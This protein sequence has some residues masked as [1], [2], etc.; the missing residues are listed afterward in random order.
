MCTVYHMCYPK[1]T[2]IN[3]IQTLVDQGKITGINYCTGPLMNTEDIDQTLCYIS[4][5]YSGKIGG[6]NLPIYKHENNNIYDYF[7]FDEPCEFNSSNKGITNNDYENLK[8]YIDR[9][10]ETLEGG[11]SLNSSMPYYKNRDK[12][13]TSTSE[14]DTA[15]SNLVIG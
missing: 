15:L 7:N 8:Y 11:H 13:T 14:F 9:L 10:L 4:L 6:D 5:F 12:L 1:R 2:F 3:Y